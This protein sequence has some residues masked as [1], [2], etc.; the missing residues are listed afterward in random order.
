MRWDPDS[1][2]I[3]DGLTATDWGKDKSMMLDEVTIYYNV[4]HPLSRAPL[5]PGRRPPTAARRPQQVEASSAASLHFAQTST[6]QQLCRALPL[7][8]SH[9]G[10][11]NG[12]VRRKQGLS[13]DKMPCTLPLG[14][15]KGPQLQDLQIILIKEETETKFNEKPVAALI[16]K[17]IQSNISSYIFCFTICHNHW[18]CMKMGHNCVT[19]KW[20]LFKENPD[21][22]FQT[23]SDKPKS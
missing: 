15:S 1:L 22:F 9:L 2:C 18:V 6:P 3:P 16:P 11:V 12:L 23:C 20:Q 21:Q 8:G 5:A 10:Q 7:K 19:P 4:A 13:E 14:R 17:N